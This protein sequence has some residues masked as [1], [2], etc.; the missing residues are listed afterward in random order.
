MARMPGAREAV[1]TCSTVRAKKGGLRAGERMVQK[2]AP[3]KVGPT[4]AL[5]RELGRSF[6]L[7]SRK[8]ARWASAPFIFLLCR[9]GVSHRSPAHEV[10]LRHRSS[11]PWKWEVGQA[12][13]AVSSTSSWFL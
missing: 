7:E 10:V 11:W 4:Q 5:N 8:Q 6:R 1:G 3:L 2:A 9:F 13:W 12:G